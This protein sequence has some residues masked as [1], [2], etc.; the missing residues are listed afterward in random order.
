MG[1]A[2]SRILP[3]CSEG[4]KASYF[5]G[6]AE[7]QAEADAVRATELAAEKVRALP[8]TS[9]HRM[10]AERQQAD[11]QAPGGVFRRWWRGSATPATVALFAVVGF[12][13]LAAAGYR[14]LEGVTR[15]A[16][17]QVQPRAAQARPE[18]LPPPPRQ[19]VAVVPRPEPVN[20]LEAR[21]RAKR[22][23]AAYLKVN[24]THHQLM[25]AEVLTRCCE[26]PKALEV[27]N[28]ACKDSLWSRRQR[29][30]AALARLGKKTGYSVLKKDL[31]HRRRAVRWAAAFTLARLGNDSGLPVIRPLLRKKRYRLTC[32]VALVKVGHD[33]A[34]RF[35]TRILKAAAAP[36]SDRLRAAVALGKSGDG[37]G[38]SL[39]REALKGQQVHLGAAVAL[40]RLGDPAAT[41][42]LV[43]ALDHTALRLEA[44]RELN[45]LGQQV[46]VDKLARRMEDADVHGQVTAAA[47]LMLLTRDAQAEV[48]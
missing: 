27:L 16:A 40:A 29:A 8:E 12:A 26:A 1:I 42:A 11:A 13:A 5:V 36:S 24:G 43:R 37:R 28:K 4:C 31:K 9:P 19:R 44:A 41:R 35:L 46:N 15:P 21:G 33:K 45:R 22:L 23:L 47:A 48:R 6:E 32:A 7:R 17:P 2:G 34:K 18:P 39:L 20:P 38:A 14:L 25:A 10:A 30:A 3:F